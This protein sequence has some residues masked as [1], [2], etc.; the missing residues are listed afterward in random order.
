[1]CAASLTGMPEPCAPY[2]PPATS[3]MT[4]TMVSVSS[5]TARRLGTASAASAS[6]L[7]ILL[8]PSLRPC[9]WRRL[10]ACLGAQGSHTQVL[11]FARRAPALIC[12]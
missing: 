8:G 10:A 3:L 7:D 12:G 6:F 9:P 2:S 11:W 1:M 5:A 4:P